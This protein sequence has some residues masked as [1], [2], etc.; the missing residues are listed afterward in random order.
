MC[1]IIGYIGPRDVKEVLL[2]SLQKLEYRGYDSA[3]VC[4]FDGSHFQRVRSKGNIARLHFKLK[5]HHFTGSIGI[6]HTRWATHGDSSEK[7]AHP[8]VVNGVAVVHNGIIE[9]FM[10]I[11]EEL[12][13]KGCKIRSE[14]DSELIAHLISLS[15]KAEKNLYKA[16]VETRRRLKGAYSILCVWD[17]EPEQIF[18]IKQGPP[19]ILG[20]GKEELFVS[21]DLQALLPYTSQIIRLADR[22]LLQIKPNGKFVLFSEKD[23][24]IKK[25]IQEIRADSLQAR[26][27][28]YSHFMLK[29]IMEQ[30][31]VLT[32]VISSYIDLNTHQLKMNLKI[33][34]P[35]KQILILACG[36]S[37]YAGK[38]GE[39]FMEDVTD[40]PVK[41]EIASEFRYKKQ[42]VLT[43]TLLIFISQS[44][45]TADTLAAIDKVKNREDVVTLS[46][47]N[48]P[49]SSLDL[50]TQNTLY[51]NAGVEIGVASTKA[52]VSTLVLLKL[53]ALRLSHLQGQRQV[54]RQ[55]QT[56]A[57]VQVQA[58]EQKEKSDNNIAYQKKFFQDLIAL[59]S[60]MERVLN[61]SKSLEK[62]AQDLKS[63]KGFLYIGRGFS[64]PIALEGALK[65]KELAYVHAEAYAAGEI[66]HGPLALV[67]KKIALIAIAPKDEHYIKTLS[68][69]EEV[70]ARGGALIAIGSEKDT[71]LRQKS[72]HYFGIPSTDRSL[73]PILCTILVQLL[74]YHLAKNM[75]CNVDQPRNLAKSVTVE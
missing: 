7:N 12:L 9:N 5:E 29:E 58:Q 20:L 40:L 54:Q 18:A 72:R 61:Y 30:P 69:I 21:S 19:L 67:D 68:N 6:G 11:R 74:A 26:K 59:P 14:T 48:T 15:L 43:G 35:I 10:E 42:K 49:N 47:C 50:K 45:E 38:L 66:K 22:E 51:M 71:L 36:S 41:T 56:Q 2:Q 16:L 4:I 65:L 31:K 1:G 17:K 23:E 25:Q 28:G 57:Q 52:F 60:Q 24:E 53:L 63:F 75:G 64:Y 13:A 46:I 62:V 55:G 32:S 39:Y 34:I 73:Y 37:Y 44:G 27:E 8:H 33:P 70:I 3:G